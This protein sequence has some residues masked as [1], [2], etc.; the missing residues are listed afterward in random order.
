MTFVKSLEKVFILIILL[1]LSFIGYNWYQTQAFKTNPLSK[2]IQNRVMDRK[3]HVLSL[4]K[5]RYNIQPNIPLYISDEFHSRL[6]GLTSHENGETKVILNKKRF[7]ESMDYMIDEVIPH[8]YA[9]AMVFILGKESSKDGHTKAW[10][11]ICLELEGKYCQ[12]Y[13]DNEEIIRQKMGM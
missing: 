3:S 13:V 1:A 5:H 9:H 6:Y 4:I 7:K 11:K 8:E 12:R 2:V 10:Q